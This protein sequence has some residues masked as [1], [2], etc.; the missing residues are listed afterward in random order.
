MLFQ[1]K[2]RGSLISESS[3]VGALG[4]IELNEEGD[5]IPSVYDIWQIVD[6]KWQ[7]TG[8][9]DSNTKEIGK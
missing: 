7:V 5:L 3:Y 9:Y 8:Y 2:K 6:D 4:D 1:L